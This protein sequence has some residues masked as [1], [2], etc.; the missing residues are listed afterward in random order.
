LSSDKA[1]LIVQAAFAARSWALSKGRSQSALSSLVLHR[2]LKITDKNCLK[3]CISS[4][5]P[6]AADVQ[7]YVRVALNVNLVQ[8]YG[9]TETSG[10][11]AV[12]CINKFEVIRMS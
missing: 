9:L 1:N 12:Q 5:S 3:V 8:L 6:L 7:Q 10:I 2:G 11:G 4:G